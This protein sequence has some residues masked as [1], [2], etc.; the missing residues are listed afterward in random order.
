MFKKLNILSWSNKDTKS[1]QKPSNLISR[2]QHL[3]VTHKMKKKC[4]QFFLQLPSCTGGLVGLPGA[5]WGL[6]GPRRSACGLKGL[7]ETVWGRGWPWGHSGLEG[8]QGFAGDCK[9]MRGAT[10]SC[11]VQRWTV[12]SRRHLGDK[13]WAKLALVLLSRDLIQKTG[14]KE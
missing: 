7:Q 4:T 1:D 8:S 5:L 10:W 12:E 2:K 11:R 9:G 14:E 3:A 6:K 13:P